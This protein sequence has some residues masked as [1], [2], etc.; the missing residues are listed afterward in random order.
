MT[1]RSLFK[2][3]VAGLLSAL[4]VFN[5]FVPVAA[6]ESAADR[7][8]EAIQKESESRLDPNEVIR[9]SI[10]LEEKSTLEAGYS[11]VAIAA[12]KQAIDYRENLRSQQAIVQAAIERKLKKDL[13]VVWNLTLAANIISANVR[14]GDIAAIKT[15]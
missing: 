5:M 4:M 9:V 10:V 15:V 14:R 7:L 6:A 1:K 8:L 3:W 12:N 2:R 13:D 11:T